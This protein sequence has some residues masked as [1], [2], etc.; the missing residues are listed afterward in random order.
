MRVA[1]EVDEQ[2]PEDAIDSPRRDFVFP[3]IRDLAESDLKLVERIGARLVHA[4][5][6]AGGTDEQAG[7][8]IR[9]RRVVLPVTDQASQKIGTAQEGAVVGSG[10]AEHHMI[11]A[12]GSRV[13][14]V[15]HKFF[16]AQTTLASQLIELR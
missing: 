12:T 3:W 5:M 6:L 13:P 9:Q 1:G 16:G 14:P 11:S 10:A 15:D 2:V 4:R 7:E 8:K